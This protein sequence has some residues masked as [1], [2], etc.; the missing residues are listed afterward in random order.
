MA[1]D[2]K[3]VLNPDDDGSHPEYWIIYDA[4]GTHILVSIPHFSEHEITVY[5]LAPVTSISSV[6][7]ASDILLIMAV[8]IVICTIAAIIFVGSIGLRKRIR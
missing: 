5:S 1:D 8:Y 4:N 3:D 2:L 6:K 7:A